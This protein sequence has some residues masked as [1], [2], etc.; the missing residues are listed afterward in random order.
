[1]EGLWSTVCSSSWSWKQDLWRNPHQA[2]GVCQQL[3]CGDPLA[4]GC[5]SLLN[6]SQHQILCHG[7]LGSFSN[8]SRNS[9]AKCLPLTLIC[10]GV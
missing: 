5:F 7:P 3:G 8:C 9:P 2:S 6:R 10:Q 4:L 1:M